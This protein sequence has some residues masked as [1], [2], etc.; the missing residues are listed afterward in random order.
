M[1]AEVR[2]FHSPDIT[3]LDAYMPLDPA[4]F[5]FLLQAVTR[6]QRSS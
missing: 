4:N 1:K 3:D 2:R 5:A 6:R